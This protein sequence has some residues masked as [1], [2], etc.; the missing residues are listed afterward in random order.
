LKIKIGRWAL[1]LFAALVAWS[2]SAQAQEKPPEKPP[3][4]VQVT[5]KN[6]EFAPPVIHMKA[7]EKIQLKVTSVDR[8]HGIHINP[9]P[10][11]GQPNSP[12]GLSFTYG[13]DCLKLKK[14]LTNTLEFTAEAPGIYAF[15]CCKKC[16]TGHARMK[17]QII[18][19]P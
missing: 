1:A 8:T 19:E 6:F 10:E 13:D 9:F 4:I 12:P 11:G 16:G 7:G 3:R 15:S 5:A 14:D 18:V 17:G 2:S